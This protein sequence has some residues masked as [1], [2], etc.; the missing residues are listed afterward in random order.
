[1]NKGFATILVAASVF[2]VAILLL[3]NATPKDIS[4]NS[5]FSELK[6]RLSNYEV[7]MLDVAQDC[8]WE[9]TALEINNCLNNG[10][11]SIAS[12][13]DMPYTN[14][15]I[16][17]PFSAR[18]DTNTANAQIDC[19]TTIDSGKEGYFSNKISKIIKVKKYP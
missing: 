8:N 3:S 13:F 12:I 9:K 5:N 2:V 7:A 14:C 19:I 18:T 16:T 11:T 1:M 10:S 15:Q 4:Y 6:V 17:Y